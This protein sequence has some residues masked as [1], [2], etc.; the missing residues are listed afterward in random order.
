MKKYNETIKI[1]G[2]NYID[3]DIYGNIVVKQDDK[4]DNPNPQKLEY[5]IN[6]IQ[7]IKYKI[8]YKFN[9]LKNNIN[10]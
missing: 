2:L 6:I 7:N 3:K 5:I 9:L 1:V 10:N 4:D 8:L